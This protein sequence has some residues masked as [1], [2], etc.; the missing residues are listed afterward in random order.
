[1]SPGVGTPLGKPRRDLS[2]FLDRQPCRP[3]DVADHAGGALPLVPSLEPAGDAASEQGA[4]AFQCG[5]NGLFTEHRNSRGGL[6][7]TLAV[8]IA[9]FPLSP[10]SPPAAPDGGP[11]SGLIDGQL[12]RPWDHKERNDLKT[13]EKD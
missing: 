1:M 2:A 10:E 6:R 5:R 12:V 8:Q 11:R 4:A 3:L 7:L 9:T 13:G